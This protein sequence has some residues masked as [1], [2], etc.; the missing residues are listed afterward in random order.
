MSNASLGGNGVLRGN[1]LSDETTVE[2]DR[3]RA[4]GVVAAGGR[5]PPGGRAADKVRI[6][7]VHTTAAYCVRYAAY[8]TLCWTCMMAADSRGT[9]V[10]VWNATSQLV[11]DPA[12]LSVEQLGVLSQVL[13]YVPPAIGGEQSRV[14][15]LMLAAMDAKVGGHDAEAEL[16]AVKVMDELERQVDEVQ[17][18]P[19]RGYS[20]WPRAPDRVFTPVDRVGQ[21]R[22]HADR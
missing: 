14:P 21:Y 15:A 6:R 12:L 11:D 3:T 18:G 17:A 1:S 20:L 4:T 2:R 16:L 19:G 13:A 10:D 7:Y 9:T 22:V 5:G 8:C